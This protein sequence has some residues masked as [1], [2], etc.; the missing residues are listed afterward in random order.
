F[1]DFVFDILGLKSENASSGNSE[2]LS[3]VVNLLLNLRMEAKANKD[4]ATSD[5]I[6]N[7]LSALGFEIKDK[8]DGFEWEL[9]K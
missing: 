3:D 6:R 5:K 4:W 7:E 9:K 2:V 1:N 8:K